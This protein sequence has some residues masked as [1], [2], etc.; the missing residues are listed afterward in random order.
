M[1]NIDNN[2]IIYIACPANVET[3]GPEALH[4]LGYELIQL[5]FNTC[6]FYYNVSENKDPVVEKYKRFNIPYKLEIEDDKNNILVLPEVCTNLLYTYKN[7]QKVFWCLS[8]DNY[9]KGL[10]Q[11]HGL[12][13]F[14]RKF[15][16]KKDYNKIDFEDKTITHLA[17]SY[18]AMQFLDEHNVENKAFLGDYLSEEFTNNIKYNIEQKENIVL[19][20]PKKGFEFTSKIIENSKDIIYIPIQNMSCAKVKS[21][22]QRSKV[23]IDFGNHP[24]KDRFP[25]EAALLGNIIITGRR[26]SANN[27]VDIPIPDMY[28]FEDNIESIDNIIAMIKN[29]LENY[30]DK[31]SDFEL[32]RKFILNDKESFINDIKTIFQKN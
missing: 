31:I 22:L 27:N 20:N 8:V 17:Q 6:M 19:Y 12:K 13:K 10:K 2:T 18:Y 25:R 24:G 29:C 30:H 21:L 32:Y 16:P 7:I 28:K 1:F 11:Y 14:Y 15:F 3:G 4:S 26:G 23:Y 5:G 9:L